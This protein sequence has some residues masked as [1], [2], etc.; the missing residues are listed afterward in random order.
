M[1][2]SETIEKHINRRNV[3]EIGEVKVARAYL[4]SASHEICIELVAERK[5][6]Q[7]TVQ[8][9]QQIYLR[10]TGTLNNVLHRATGFVLNHEA[11]VKGE[12]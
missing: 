7:L 5:V 1:T 10:H 9:N 4:Y 6:Y 11:T 8:A 3:I 2:F 12:I